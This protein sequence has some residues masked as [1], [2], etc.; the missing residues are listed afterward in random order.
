KEANAGLF[1]N[2]RNVA[3]VPGY[4]IVD[5][6]ERCKSHVHGIGEKLSVK[7][8]PRDI[9]LRK[10]RHLLG[11]FKLGKCV[12]KLQVSSTVRFRNVLQFAADKRRGVRCVLAKLAFEPAD[13]EVASKWIVVIEIRSYYGCLEVECEFHWIERTADQGSTSIGEKLTTEFEKSN[14]IR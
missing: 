1:A 10:D 8:A 7:D 3:E 14:V 9:T 4:E 13:S 11:E 5:L 2:V 12:D 6:V